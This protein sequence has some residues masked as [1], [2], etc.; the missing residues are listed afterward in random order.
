[1]TRAHPRLAPAAESFRKTPLL[2]PV[3][4]DSKRWQQ[5]GQLYHAA[6]EREPKDRAAFLAEACQ[7]DDELRREVESLLAQKDWSSGALMNRP[8]WQAVTDLSG[9]STATQPGETALLGFPPGTILAQRYRIVNLLGQ[10]GMGEVYRADD[11]LL[12]QPVALKFLPRAASS[13][14]GLLARFRNEVRMARQVAHPNVCRVYDIGEAEGLTYLTMEYVDGEDLASLLRR[15]GKLPQDK[16]LEVARKLCAGLAAAHDKGVIHRDLKPSN[17]MLDGK[18][19]VRITDFGLAGVAE[20]I[21][22]LRSGTP[23]YMAPEQLVGREVTPRSDVYALGLVLHE[24]FTGKRPSRET[25]NPE[26]DPVVERVILRCLEEDPSMRPA[27][28][29]SVAAALPGGD[30]LAAALASGETPS[31][32]VIAKAG[33]LEGMRVP[34]AVACLAAV[35]IGLTVFSFVRQRHDMI[36][37][38]PMENSPQVLAAKA[39]DIAKSLG[40]TERPVDTTFGW[41]YDADTLRYLAAQKDDSVRKARLKA[42][43]PAALHFWYRE[44]PRRL[45]NL[46]GQSITRYQ[47][48]GFDPGMLEAILDSEGRLVE[49]QAQPPSETQTQ[50]PPRLPDWSR[51]FAAA[52]LDTGRFT[53]V[54]PVLT[55]RSYSDIRAAW[56][57]FSDDVPHEPVRVE[58]AAYGGRPVFFVTLGPWSR[59]DRV[60]PAPLGALTFRTLLV[61]AVVLPVGAGLLAWQNTRKGRGDRR[62]AFRVASFAFFCVFFQILAFQKHVPTIEEIGVL[63]LAMRDALTSA[64]I[65]WVLYTAFEPYVRKRSP[66]TLISW[67]RLLAGRLRD[68]LVGT[69][70]LTGCVLAVVGLCIV[71]PL[72]SPFVASLAPP[73]MPNILAWLSLF[74]WLLIVAV[75]TALSCIFLLTLLLLLVRL[76]WLAA[77]LFVGV[78]SLAFASYGAPLSAVVFSCFLWYALTRFGVLST[79]AY[80]YVYNIVVGFPSPIN[81]SAWYAEIATLAGLVILALAVYAFRITLAGRPLWAPGP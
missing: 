76:Q 29:L 57:G 46:S 67:S 28:A 62:G 11:L 80:L 59:Q 56:T 41:E 81:Q 39:R 55:P 66:A 16:A 72:V 60:A 25:R 71:R 18:G 5:I 45:Y 68:P 14:A 50:D 2:E 51:L 44:S 53:P 58:A 20:Q 43:R 27:T 63:F 47:P 34:V 12:G 19:Q 74:S 54:K 26:L 13:D 38:I 32:E 40:Y 22:D 10:G 17:I 15:I 75:G 24:L 42:N 79:S 37:R 9:D 69:D 8:A 35:I 3:S 49:F 33:T 70:L 6:L 77:L 73:L 7:S 21:R 65:F 4:M 64:A 30:P 61:F 23:A 1:M 48:H 31:P 78:L 52:G 36:H